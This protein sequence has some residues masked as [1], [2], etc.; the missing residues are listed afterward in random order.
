[1]PPL[2][3][4][5]ILAS[6]AYFFSIPWHPFPGVVV[7]K[8]LAV[9]PLAVLAWRNAEPLLGTALAFSSFGDVLLEI[10]PD[11]FTF[12]L[13]AFLCSHLV[14]TT[15][16]LRKR[17]QPVEATQ[18]GMMLAAAV[19]SVSFAV[20]LTPHLGKLGAPVWAYMAAITAMVLSSIASRI[21]PTWVVAGALL[22]LASDSILAANKFVGP[23]PL[24]GWL[25][26]STYALAQYG[27]CL[28]V[29]SAGASGAPRKATAAA[30]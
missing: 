24:R 7:L 26:W 23:V 22:F 6:T 25:V 5:S 17:T 9:A 1:M 29:L 28:G 16:F 8:G 2:L 14:Y 21:R 11:M 19:F 3:L 15:M 30:S 13:A 20:W 4:V 27:L 18:I 10:S 12:G